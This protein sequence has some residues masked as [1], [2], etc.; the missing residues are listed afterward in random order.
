M[1]IRMKEDMR[2]IHK[3]YAV[4]CFHTHASIYSKL[5]NLISN[6]Y[7]DERGYAYYTQE[8]CSYVFP[9]TCFNIFETR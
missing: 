5:D 2:I 3:K 9:H 7:E 6:G 1:A 8:V 4:M